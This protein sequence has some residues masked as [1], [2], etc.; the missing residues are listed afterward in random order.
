LVVTTGLGDFTVG[1]ARPVI[2]TV[3]DFP[4]FSTDK[5]LD[6][7]TGFIRASYT[8]F[9]GYLADELI[10]GVSLTG[11]SGALSYGASVQQTD[12]EGADYQASQIAL[13]YD[14]GNVALLGGIET[15]TL[16]PLEVSTLLLGVLYSD[17]RLTAGVEVAERRATGSDSIRLTRLH[18]AYDVNPAVTLTADFGRVN[19]GTS[20]DDLWSVGAEYRFGEVGFVQGSYSDDGAE[21]NFS[22]GLGFRF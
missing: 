3:Y 15:A 6:F 20:D 8:S 10:Y 22:V 4:D 18:A 11:Q 19:T 16:T 14:L 9:L 13:R 7:N 1:F 17:D 12:L 5:V 2:E 21:N